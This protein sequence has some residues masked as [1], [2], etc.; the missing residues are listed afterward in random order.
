M[1]DDDELRLKMGIDGWAFV[2]DNFHYTRLC[3]DMK[4]L[5]D[6]LLK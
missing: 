3:N 5:Y 4:A 6:D 2:K 1:V